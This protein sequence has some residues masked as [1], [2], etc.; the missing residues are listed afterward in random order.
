MALLLIGKKLIDCYKA[1]APEGDH[2]AMVKAHHEM[3]QTPEMYQLIVA[4]DG[5]REALD[6]LH[7]V[8]LETAIQT[9]RGRDSLVPIFEH[10]GISDVFDTILTHEDVTEP[11]PNPEGIR[12]IAERLNIKPEEMIMVGDT[13]I[14][15][16]TA[17]NA[18]MAGAVGV[19]HGFGT[20]QELRIA[21][22]KEIVAGLGEVPKALRS[23]SYGS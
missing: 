19:L 5:L 14:D 9:N 12:I 23:M 11:K 15:V 20:E 10:I 16:L 22:A 4:Y 6:E 7:K 8:G 18:G 17:T 3:Q 2:E 13:A 21:G 1:L